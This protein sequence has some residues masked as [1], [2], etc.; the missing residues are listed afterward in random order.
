VAATLKYFESEM[1]F[2]LTQ[3]APRDAYKLLAGL[4]VPRPIALVTTLDHDGKVNAAPFSFFN[5]VGSDPP[6]VVFAPGQGSPHTPANIRARGEFVVNLV[7]EAIAAQ[8]NICAID[9]PAGHSEVEAA[10]FALEA[11]VQVSVPRIAQSPASLECREHSTLEIGRNRL[12]IG[13]V[14]HIHAREGLVS[15]RLHV[16]H[17]KLQLIGRLAGSEYCRTRETFEMARLNYE[18]W[19]ENQQSSI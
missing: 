2:D 1:D 16:A 15:D 14:L 5:C 17:E 10:G 4:I 12:V 3:L 6:L 8:M 18:Q 11:G 7:D 13:Q 9:F 19:L